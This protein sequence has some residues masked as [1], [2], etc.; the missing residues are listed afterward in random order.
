[1]MLAFVKAIVVSGRIA[2]GLGWI[3]KNHY[4]DFMFLRVS[5]GDLLCYYQRGKSGWDEVR[6][7]DTLYNYFIIIIDGGFNILIDFIAVLG[8]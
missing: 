3:Q 8:L 1:M 4:T 6:F 2:F 7:Y 5:V